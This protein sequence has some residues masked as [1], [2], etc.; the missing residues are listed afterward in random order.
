MQLSAQ[1]DPNIQL[2]EFIDAVNAQF[3][4]ALSLGNTVCLDESMV[5]SFHKIPKNILH[6]EMYEGKEYMKHKKH[7]HELGATAETLKGSE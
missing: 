2:L 5:K 7:L 6:I 1:P 3:K 4:V